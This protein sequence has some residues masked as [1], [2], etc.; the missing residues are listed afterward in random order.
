MIA[1]KNIHSKFH[2]IS[3]IPSQIDFQ[4]VK[5][6]IKYIDDPSHLNIEIFKFEKWRN[7]WKF[8]NKKIFGQLVC[9]ILNPDFLRR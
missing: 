5:S 6:T 3:C 4:L 2:I 7:S 9:Y 1:I 8:Q